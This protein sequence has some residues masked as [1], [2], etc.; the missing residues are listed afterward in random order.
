[1]LVHASLNESF[2]CYDI[3]FDIFL[4]EVRMSFKKKKKKL[5]H[6]LIFDLPIFEKGKVLRDASSTF[7]QQL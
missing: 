3:I 1:M 5:T 7:F 2:L 6:I 4:F